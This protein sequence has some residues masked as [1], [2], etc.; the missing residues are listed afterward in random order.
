MQ[1]I[2]LALGKNGLENLVEEVLYLKK[3]TREMIDELVH[4]VVNEPIEKRDQ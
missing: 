3:I 2:S 1:N 4:R